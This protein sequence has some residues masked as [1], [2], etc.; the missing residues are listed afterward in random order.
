MRAGPLSDPKVIDLLN[1][2]FVPLYTS[3]DELPGDSADRVKR[4]AAE[5]EKQIRAF[6]AAGLGTGSVTVYILTADARPF[7]RL[8]VVKAAENDHNLRQLLENV[9]ADLKVVRGAPIIR[10]SPQ[11]KP[12]RAGAEDLVLHLTARKL[13]P[14]YS[15]NEFPSESWIVL[16][17][18]DWRS[19]IPAEDAIGASH[20]IEKAVAARILTHIYPQTEVCTADE[21]KL[22]SVE[23][24]YRH[25]IDEQVLKSTIVSREKGI[26]RA[27]LEGRV[28]LHHDFYPSRPDS[29][30]AVVAALVGYLDYDSGARKIAKLRLVTREAAY[31]KTPIGVA[32]RSLPAVAGD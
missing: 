20:D 21:T 26:V 1:A 12:P 3:N 10:P 24:P 6:D 7:T 18:A 14:K 28:K 31:G 32:V 19:L 4:E 8:G 5:R 27:R 11:A 25:A 9:A 2:L 15:W 30:A 29:R 13:Q 17:P 23:G 16:S 22:L